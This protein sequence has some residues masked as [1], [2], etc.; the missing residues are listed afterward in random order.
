MERRDQ[1]RVK[2]EKKQQDDITSGQK[3]QHLQLSLSATSYSYET[4]SKKP[5]EVISTLFYFLLEQDSFL[6][7]SKQATFDD[8]GAKPRSNKP[9]QGNASV[10]YSQSEDL[11]GLFLIFTERTIKQEHGS[12]LKY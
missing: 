10:Y 5:H 11:F 3:R 4:I 8:Q 2:I 1:G 6:R 7:S 12:T 9:S